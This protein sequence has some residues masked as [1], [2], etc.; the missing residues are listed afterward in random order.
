MTLKQICTFD[1]YALRS[2]I[3]KILLEVSGS[4]VEHLT[5]DRRAAGSSLAGDTAL[6]P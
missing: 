5:R 3:N 1:V 6:C 4:V 2:D